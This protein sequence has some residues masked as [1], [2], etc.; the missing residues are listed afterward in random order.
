MK[1]SL[2]ILF[3][4]FYTFTFCQE[5]TTNKKFIYHTE[6]NFKGSFLLPHVNEVKY[7][8]NGTLPIYEI[9]AEFPT[10][11]NSH[12][13]NNFPHN[14]WGIMLNFSPLTG[15][16]N[17]GVSI[18]IL[19]Y[20]NIN[21]LINKE[22][23]WKFRLAS[24]LG[25][26]QKPFN[27]IDNPKNLAIGSFLNN[28][29]DFTIQYQTY[30]PLDL[31]AKIG[32]GMQHFSNGA[33]TRPNHGLNLPY[34]SLAL[35]S[36]KKKTEL[37]NKDKKV[38]NEK[39]SFFISSF[40]G[41]KTLT[42]GAEKRYHVFQLT[43]GYSL[44]FTKGNFIHMQSDIIIDNSLPYLKEYDFEF[45][46]F[47]KVII[48]L[49]SNYEKKFGQIGLLVGL[50]LYLHSPFQ[51]FNTDWSY[52]NNGSIFYNRIGVKYHIS[53]LI[54]TQISVRTHMEGAD[55]TEFGIGYKF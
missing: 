10:L 38:T 28:I 32:F 21:C 23:R 33:F 46:T 27:K 9:G 12:F 50:G 24:G 3:S 39:N 54:F 34:I 35:K 55:N 36:Q 8:M 29:T 42:F 7:L 41:S 4:L 53:K 30:I 13:Q 14:N 25:F 5:K 16:E 45:E 49:F 6:V 26:I 22:S 43:G 48:G 18:G 20:L 19:P 40:Y 31:I 15:N 52:A 17:L 37:D 1:L 51:T 44:G 11:G 47:D 2:S